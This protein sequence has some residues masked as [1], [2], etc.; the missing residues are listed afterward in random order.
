MTD[1]NTHIKK[2]NTLYMS[3][4]P[5]SY[6]V[7]VLGTSLEMTRGTIGLDMAKH[8][9]MR[10]SFA[11]SM[12]HWGSGEY[13]HQD[14]WADLDK[15][16]ELPDF[17]LT[18]DLFHDFGIRLQSGFE[19]TVVDGQGKLIAD[20][21]ERVKDG[22]NDGLALKSVG[23]ST[24]GGWFEP[25]NDNEA[26]FGELQVISDGQG[27]HE[28]LIHTNKPFDPDLISISFTEYDGWPVTSEVSYDGKP[29]PLSDNACGYDLIIGRVHLSRQ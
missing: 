29:L 10:G 2:N 24:G 14:V 16:Y 5:K 3:T 27:Y 12:V 6:F 22:Y 19:V 13:V 25:C 15:K 20:I 28:Y 26:S 18:D 23:L 11:L 21:T 4:R 8:W 9:A 7:R 1:Y 17:G